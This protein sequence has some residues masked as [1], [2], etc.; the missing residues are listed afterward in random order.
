VGYRQWHTKAGKKPAHVPKNAHV[1]FSVNG[2][3]FVPGFAAVSNLLRQQ[4][5]RNIPSIGVAKPHFRFLPLHNKTL[6]DPEHFFETWNVPAGFEPARQRKSVN[7]SMLVP[8]T[9]R[10]LSKS[11]C[12]ACVR[13]TIYKW[14]HICT[15]HEHAASSDS[16]SS[17]IYKWKHICTTYVLAASNDSCSSS[18]S[19][20]VL[21]GR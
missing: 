18:E 10:S 14:K 15:K 17:T 7:R 1:E 5:G 20:C 2:C 16:C 8:E 9:G 3:I 11:L 19:T 21:S 12:G 6:S 4:S 13:A